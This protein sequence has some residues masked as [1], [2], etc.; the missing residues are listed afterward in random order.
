VRGQRALLGHGR[1]WAGNGL[2]LLKQ[3]VTFRFHFNIPL[4]SQGAF[5]LKENREGG[6]WGAMFRLIC[7]QQMAL[8]LH[9]ALFENLKNYM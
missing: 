8:E 5:N 4:T 3:M 6:R 2:P 9:L 1:D 7:P